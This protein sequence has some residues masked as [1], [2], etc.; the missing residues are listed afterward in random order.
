LDNFPVLPGTV[1]WTPSG[2]LIVLMR[3]GQTTGGYPRILQLTE[4]S[5]NVLAQKNT[6]Q[7]IYIAAKELN[8]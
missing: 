3:E 5:I 4:G 6:N 1:Q 2:Q 8:L 7:S